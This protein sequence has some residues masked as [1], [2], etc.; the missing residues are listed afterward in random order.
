[1]SSAPKGFTL[2]ELLIVVAIVGIL[3]T[4]ALPAYQD[5]TVRTKITE[6]LNLCAAIKIA[7]AEWFMSKGTMPADNL[8]I[9]MP[10]PEAI[11]S[12]YVASVAVNDGIITIEYAKTGIGGN[13]SMNSAKVTLTP[14]STAGSVIW[15]CAIGSRTE[16]YKYVPAE[17]RN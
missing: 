16:V 1:M 12:R 4:L 2:I 10:E 14:V 5:Y 9:D 3:A 7:V 15:Q 13:P 11:K 6:G 8:A 17:C